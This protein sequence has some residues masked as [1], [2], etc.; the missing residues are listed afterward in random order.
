[1]DLRIPE[2]N[3]SFFSMLAEPVRLSILRCL[4]VKGTCSVSELMEKLAKPQTLVSYHLR[5]LKD[6]ELV[7]GRKSDED[8]RQ[9][10]YSLHDR[11]FLLKLFEMADDYVVKHI[12]CKDH[13]G[14]R[15]KESP[16]LSNDSV[17]K[18]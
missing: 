9:I 5:C 7:D 6:C 14:C 15:A 13:D 10:R 4:L 8:A 1:M 16:T 2:R 11:S 12:Q 3:I 17:T 18:P